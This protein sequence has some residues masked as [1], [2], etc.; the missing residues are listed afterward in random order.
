[1]GTASVNPGGQ[2]RNR[3][4]SALMNRTT[5]GPRHMA[6]SG[7]CVKR[8]L[9]ILTTL[10][11]G[12]QGN[13]FPLCCHERRAALQ[14]HPPGQRDG[15]SPQAKCGDLIPPG[16][17]VH[18]QPSLDHGSLITTPAPQASASRE[19]FLIPTSPLLWGLPSL[20]APPLHPCAGPGPTLT[21]SALP[22]GSGLPLGAG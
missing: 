7:P 9:G 13:A 3:E 19:V 1:M 17:G 16:R 18:T 5:L 12:H 15:P 10:L 21:A 20:A 4:E 2:E 8:T 11:F 22:K 6:V 14:K